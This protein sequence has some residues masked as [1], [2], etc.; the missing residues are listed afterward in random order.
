MKYLPLL[1]LLLLAACNQHTD[2]K[3]KSIVE[4]LDPALDA[5]VDSDA[6]MEVIGTGYE[7]SEGSL[8]VPTQQM[9]LFSDVPNNIVYKWTREKG[10]ET[11]LTPSG[12]MG[13]DE[14]SNE[15]GSNGLVLDAENNLVLCQQGE[16]RMAMMQAP[17]DHPK[18]SFLALADNYQGKKFNSPNDACYDANGNLYFTDP[19]YGLPEQENSPIKE[20]PFQGVYKMAPN[21]T[22]TLL[23]DSITRPNGIAVSPDNKYLYVANSDPGK[24]YWYRY[25]LGDSTLV[26]GGIFYDAMPLTK[27]SNGVPDGMKIDKNGNILGAGPGGICIINPEGKLL[28]RI[29]FD[30]S[31]S[32]CAL[33]DDDKT[34][35]VTNDN[36]VVRIQLRK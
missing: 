33:A 16:R 32:N 34:L 30:S 4:R 15:P 25:E 5:I 26:A 8:W 27:T 1:A 18:P 12:Y 28:G 11:Y 9:L 13:T 23:L 35:Y 2:S 22:V 10:I 14:Y 20:L 24:A 7:W 17:L 19:P 21:G 29:R 31:I 6:K 36:Q 3:E